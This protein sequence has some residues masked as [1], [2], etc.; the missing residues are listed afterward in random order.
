MKS[1]RHKETGKRGF[2]KL[3]RSQWLKTGMG[4]GISDKE[5]FMFTPLRIS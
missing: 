4:G 1:V 3:P 5:I 2:C